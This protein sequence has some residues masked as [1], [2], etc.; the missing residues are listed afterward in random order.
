MHFLALLRA[1][2]GTEPERVSAFTRLTE[3]HL[4]PIDSVS[5]AMQLRNGALGTWVLYFMAPQKGAQIELS[6][7]VSGG[8]SGPGGMV[9]V[10]L[11]DD[12]QGH[13]GW[14]VVTDLPGAEPQ[15]TFYD[16]RGVAEEFLGFA[17]AIG[18]VAPGG[19]LPGLINETTVGYTEPFSNTARNAL[20]DVA[21]AE[22]VIQ[23]GERGGVPVQVQR[24]I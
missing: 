2:T 3:K 12:G 4:A 1:V 24:V 21:L 11:G 22:A 7:V 5:A 16:N 17:R 10:K 20:G 18:G 9:T 19:Y 8:A 6:V 15:T 23:S 13:N 14:V